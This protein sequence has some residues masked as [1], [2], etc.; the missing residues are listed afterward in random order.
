M[1]GTVGDV[2]FTD[3]G[4]YIE[5]LERIK[6]VEESETDE[7]DL[8]QE[9]DPRFTEPPLEELKI[10]RSFLLKARS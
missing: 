10:S 4:F 1:I 6:G 7:E 8:E 9:H 5:F 2:K 3:E